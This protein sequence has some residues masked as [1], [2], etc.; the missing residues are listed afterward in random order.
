MIKAIIFDYGGVFSKEADLHKFAD[1]YA[2]KYG[3]DP[4]K[5]GDEMYEYWQKA[6]VNKIN[7]ALFFEHLAGQLDVDVDEFTEYFIHWFGF[8]EEIKEFVASL[9]GRY[10]LGLLSNQ[11][12]IWLETL[13]DH[14]DIRRLFDVITTSYNEGI[15]KPDPKIYK[16]AMKA[17]GVKP[18]ECVFIDD[19]ERNIKPAEKLGMKVV[20]YKGLKDLK[21]RLVEF[22]ITL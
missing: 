14:H 7:S 17:L 15:A 13:L 3:I 11:I 21:K 6:K 18:E 10:K 5:F 1:H 22:G 2:P 4:K 16:R 8:D 9:Q 12:E 20:T 19:L